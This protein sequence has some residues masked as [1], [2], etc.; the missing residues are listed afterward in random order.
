[1]IYQDAQAGEENAEPEVLSEFKLLEKFAPHLKPGNPKQAKLRKQWIEAFTTI[2]ALPASI[3]VKLERLDSKKLFADRL[4][5]FEVLEEQ[6]T[7]AKKAL[8]EAAVGAISDTTIEDIEQ[9]S[10]H[11]VTKSGKTQ[12]GIIEYY[13][14]RSKAPIKDV[15]EKVGSSVSAEVREQLEELGSKRAKEASVRKPAKTNA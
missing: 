1:M 13:V 5:T 10:I 3:G 12:V 9:G 11:S 15:V 8:F 6:Y 7:T 2:E 4:Q 14:K